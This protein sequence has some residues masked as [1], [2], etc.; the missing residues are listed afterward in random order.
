MYTEKKDW[1]NT[2]WFVAPYSE[3]EWYIICMYDVCMH[4]YVRKTYSQA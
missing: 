4:V 2:T 3:S 1:S